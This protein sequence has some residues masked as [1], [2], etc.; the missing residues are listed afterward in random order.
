MSTA[1]L[2]ERISVANVDD[3]F[4]NIDFTNEAPL[5]RIVDYINIYRDRQTNY[6]KVIVKYRNQ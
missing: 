5:N 3:S 2:S 1:N 4:I 6:Q